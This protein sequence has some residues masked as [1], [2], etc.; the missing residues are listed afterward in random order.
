MD[1]KARRRLAARESKN[2]EEIFF[3]FPGFL[4]NSS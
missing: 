2:W 3:W 1:Q 4:I